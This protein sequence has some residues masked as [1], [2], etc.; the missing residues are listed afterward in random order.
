MWKNWG[1]DPVAAVMARW[2]VDRASAT[3]AIRL[4]RV[5]RRAGDPVRVSSG[6]RYPE[7]Q[8]QLSLSLPAGEALPWDVSRHSR[9]YPASA[10]D[11]SGPRERVERLA[12]RASAIQAGFR[13]AVAHRGTGWHLHAET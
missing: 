10:V 1:P 8:R 11:F 13:R 5:A 2:G 9:A 7:T 12:Q 6:Y 3:A 4:V